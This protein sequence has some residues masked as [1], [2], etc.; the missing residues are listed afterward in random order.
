MKYI[1]P[2]ARFLSKPWVLL[3]LII[4][5]TIF[6]RSYHITQRFEFAHDGDLYS[7]I[8][9]DIVVNKH[10]RLIGQLTSTPGI[11]IGPLFY[12][13]LIPFF[14]LT[15]MDPMGVL[16]FA[17]LIGTLTTISFYWVFKKLFDTTTGLLAAFI[18]ATMTVRI[19]DD[20][21]VV[22]TI[23][24]NLWGIWY[25]YVVL[26]LLRGDFGVF[27]LL[28]LL[29]GL[30]WHINFSLAPVLLVV[31]VA[32]ILSRRLPKWSD[33]AKGFI[34]MVVPLIPYFIFEFRHN[35]S[36]TRSFVESFL[37]NQ[38]GGSGLDKFFHVKQQIMGNIV[39]LFFYPARDIFISGNFFFL[40]MLGIAILLVR[41]GE[42]DKKAL[43]TLYI[44]IASVTAFFTFSSKIVSEYYF[45][46]IDTTVITFFIL[47]IA[48]IY[49]ASKMGKTIIIILLIGLLVRSIFIIV[50]GR[51]YSQK[52]YLER[53]AVV[54]YITEDSQKRGFPCVAVSYISAPGE[55]LGFR[56]LF[57]L[58]K[59]HV[60]QPQSGS[61]D[62]TIISPDNLVAEPTKYVFGALG[63]IPPTG[64]YNLDKV[65]QTCSGANS[66]LTDPLFG[67]T[68]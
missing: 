41:K 37:I 33:V 65:A 27:P 19:N 30:I 61:P 14:L 43:V 57:Y 66:N 31:P 23:T 47:G 15:S 38:G 6:F 10:L 48:W 67:Y 25:L 46:I 20:R 35:F 21:W 4:L 44:W 2:T 11:F 12:Y 62:Y 52:G 17:I 56:Y 63:V 36:Q 64:S 54:S 26:M 16:F 3:I 32:I 7:W 49:K 51:G 55:D 28:G 40:I 45:Q 22:P 18:Q 60:N 59:L 42:L 68:E 8:V 5:L 29:V 53:K 13:S 24:T 50:E 9:K 39:S 1:P 58:A 34:A